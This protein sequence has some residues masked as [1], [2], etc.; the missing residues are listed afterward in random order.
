MQRLLLYDIF[1]TDLM[2][3]TDKSSWRTICIVVLSDN[4]S[5]DVRSGILSVFI[6]RLQ[7][8][9]DNGNVYIMSTILIQ[10]YNAKVNCLTVFTRRV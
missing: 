5:R 7:I 6:M 3:L 10:A 4:T 2:S 1:S 9:E 8:S